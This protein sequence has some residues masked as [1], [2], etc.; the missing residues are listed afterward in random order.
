[1]ATPAWLLLAEVPSLADYMV[2]WEFD[3]TDRRLRI[4]ELNIPSMND[5]SA[6]RREE[7]YKSVNSAGLLHAGKQP[8]AYRWVLE[9]TRLLKGSDFIH[10]IMARINALPKRSRTA[11]GRTKSACVELERRGFNTQSV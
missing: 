2:T 5:I 1:M 4:G 6:Y 9:P 11:R 8:S 7:L 10:V 3:E